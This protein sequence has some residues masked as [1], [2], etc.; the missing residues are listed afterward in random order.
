M[1]DVVPLDEEVREDLTER[2][3]LR[4]NRT[5]ENRSKVCV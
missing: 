3:H 4:N 2:G 1:E 5:G